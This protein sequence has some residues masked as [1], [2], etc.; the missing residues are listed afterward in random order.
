MGETLQ[1]LNARRSGAYRKDRG[2]ENFFEA[3][4]DALLEREAAF[5]RDD[6]IEHPFLFIFGAP[7]SGTTLMSQ[8]AAY[9]LDAGYVNNLVARFWKAPIHGIRLSKSTLGAADRTTFQSDYARTAGVADIHEFGYFWGQ[10]FRK[11][12]M[13]E[14]VRSPEIETG[15]DWARI[16]RVLASILREFGKPW[17]AKNIY[18][19]YHLGR[20]QA[21]LE[22][23]VYIYI[24]R[25]PLDTAVSILQARRKYYDDLRTWWSYVP[26]EYP[27]LKDRDP[28]AQIAGQVYYLNR[29]YERETA[30][31]P[32][33]SVVRVHYDELCA[34]PAAVL[35]R[36]QAACRDHCGCDLRIA[37]APPAAFPRRTHDARADEKARFAGLFTALQESHD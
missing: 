28:M 20:L 29:Y 19:A 33:G 8:V 27:L 9:C 21:V 14:I 4:N 12:S 6:P 13:E 24:E 5:Y 26:L 34:D 35:G 15:L 2:A 23:V 17:V 7:R 11:G 3:M 22:N 18:G 32:A 31:L 37:T 10:L 16:R 25:D 36:I 30:A 1:D